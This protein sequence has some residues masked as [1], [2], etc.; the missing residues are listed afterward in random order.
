MC[1]KSVTVRGG[2][3]ANE[4]ALGNAFE[5]L[6]ILYTLVVE[7]SCSALVLWSRARLCVELSQ[8]ETA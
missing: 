7:R 1:K 6:G 5:G 8:L 4:G 3:Q 2:F